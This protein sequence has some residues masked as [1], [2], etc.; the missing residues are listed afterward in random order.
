MNTFTR[1]DTFSMYVPYVPGPN[2]P[3]NLSATT[4]TSSVLVG[5]SVAT[6]ATVPAT[7][8]KAG[9][10]KSFTVVIAAAVTALWPLGNMQWNVK[11][12]YSGVTFS[13]DTET[14]LILN[15]PTK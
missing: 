12:V 7:V 6:L 11:F 13:S 4:V 14:L 1:G 5:N 10:N 15:N 8:T 3:A 9:D 2:D